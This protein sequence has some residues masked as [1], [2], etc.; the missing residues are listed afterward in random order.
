MIL[1]FSGGIGILNNPL[2]TI[3]QT[4]YVLTFSRA[5]FLSVSPFSSIFSYFSYTSAEF[6]GR[7]CSPYAHE[8]WLLNFN[9]KTSCIV[10]PV[11]NSLKLPELAKQEA[12]RMRKL[13]GVPEDAAR[14]AGNLHSSICWMKCALWKWLFNSPFTIPNLGS[15]NCRA[16]Q[17]AAHRMR[18]QQGARSTLAQ[19]WS[20][21]R[22]VFVGLAGL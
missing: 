12:E 1:G 22:A 19:R 14:M 16:L 3:V 13:R 17:L 15:V 2:E 10:G 11:L 9:N 6:R 5:E 20:A 4:V 8:C 21:I 7:W 18:S